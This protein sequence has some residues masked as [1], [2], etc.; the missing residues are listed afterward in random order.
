MRS[1]ENRWSA[2]RMYSLKAARSRQRLTMISSPSSRSD[3][4]TCRS[5]NPSW[6][7]TR[8]AR[9]R[10]AVTSCSARSTGTRRRDIE[11]YIAPNASGS[12]GSRWWVECGEM[13]AD[14][15]A[16]A[17]AE[18]V[19]DGFLGAV[20]ASDLSG[21]RRVLDEAIAAGM[22]VRRIYLDVLQPTLY[23]VGR[24]WSHAEISIAQE[25]LATAATQSAMARLAESLSDGPRR[26]SP[27][28]AVVACV[29]DELHA[30]GGRMVADFLE[31]DGWR[32]ASLGQLTPGQDLAALAAEKGAQLVALSAAL[33]E[34]VPQVAEV[35]A[36]LRGLDPVPYVLVGGQAFGGSAERALRT[37]ADAFAVDAEAAASAVRERFAASP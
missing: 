20:L 18:H 6:P 34:R 4:Q 14:T 3:C 22:P 29:S 11:T 19:R 12:G 16:P 7:S 28:A 24:L 30:V 10:K 32:V 8:P 17:R 33:P 5:T 1:C 25:H 31:A 2:E 35:C 21:A 26:V 13:G 9:A 36:A 23:E 37:G 27:G 15:A